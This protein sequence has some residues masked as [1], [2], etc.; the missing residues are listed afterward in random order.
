MTT[1]YGSLEPSQLKAILELFN[2]KQLTVEKC[3]DP[4]REFQS[5][6]VPQV[7]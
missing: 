2:L 5:G 6:L 4:Y 7:H 3:L 1:M